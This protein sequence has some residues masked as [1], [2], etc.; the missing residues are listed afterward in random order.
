MLN[1]HAHASVAK[2]LGHRGRRLEFKWGGDISFGRRSVPVDLEAHM[3]GGLSS[4]AAKQ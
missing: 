1:A 3:P 2:L 4:E